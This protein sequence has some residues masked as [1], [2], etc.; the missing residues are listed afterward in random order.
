MKKSSSA[1][2]LGYSMQQSLR[3]ACSH[4]LQK[5]LKMIWTVQFLTIATFIR[6]QCK[7][8]SPCLVDARAKKKKGMDTLYTNSNV[9]QKTLH[10]TL[11][12]CDTA[13]YSYI[14]TD[15]PK[16]T[17]DMLHWT[18]FDKIPNVSIVIGF[19]IPEDNI[20]TELN[21]N[22]SVFSSSGLELQVHA[23]EDLEHHIKL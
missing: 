18:V 4:G 13:I 6:L 12:D 11:S 21:Y 15:A 17:Y 16:I 8:F 19:Q 3:L 23:G 10:T 5:H 20:I 22:L 2:P 1:F 14:S 9:T 7:P